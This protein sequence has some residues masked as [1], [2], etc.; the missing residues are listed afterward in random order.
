MNQHRFTGTPADALAVTALTGL[1]GLALVGARTM[2]RAMQKRRIWKKTT[3]GCAPDLSIY[4]DAVLHIEVDGSH[5]GFALAMLR[6]RLDENQTTAMEFG[7]AEALRACLELTINLALNLAEPECE[8]ECVCGDDDC[9][10]DAVN[11]ELLHLVAGRKM[12]EFA[13][14]FET[15]AEQH[16]T[17]CRT[18]KTAGTQSPGHLRARFAR[19]ISDDL[20]TNATSNS[21]RVHGAPIPAAMDVI[22]AMTEVTEAELGIPVA[23]QID[24]LATG[25]ASAIA[26]QEAHTAPQT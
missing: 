6:D 26:H 1:T 13:V 20:L 8:V 25:L 5:Q 4:P 18:C 12:A 7:Y 21:V 19:D 23:V 24:S 22:C 9:D 3:G 10:S 2:S 11:Y 14:A 16:A 15:Q 17:G